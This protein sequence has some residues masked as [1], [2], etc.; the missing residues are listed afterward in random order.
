MRGAKGKM[1][2]RTV[3]ASLQHSKPFSD[4]PCVLVLGI[5]S[6]LAE[7]VIRILPALWHIVVRLTGVL[8]VTPPL[9]GDFIGCSRTNAWAMAIQVHMGACDGSY[10]DGGGG[11]GMAVKNSPKP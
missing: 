10:D 5:C 2:T 3:D 1:A 7:A 6:F 9:A 4:F 11:C 8:G